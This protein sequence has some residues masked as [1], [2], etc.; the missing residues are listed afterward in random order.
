MDEEEI[1]PSEHDIKIYAVKT[2]IGREN[3]V[4]EAMTGKAKSCGLSVKAMVHPEELKGYVFVEGELKDIEAMVKEIP[5]A[6]SVL[7]K[8][9][10]MSDIKRFVEP[11]KIEIKVNEGDIVE[12]IGGPFKGEKGKVI[13]FDDIKGEVTIELIEITVPI[14]V[15]VNAGLVKLIERGK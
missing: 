3:V 13:R 2:I 15:T 6:R 10:A 8:A 1:Q 7:R 11:K 9:I 12:V 14:P 4:L 5:H